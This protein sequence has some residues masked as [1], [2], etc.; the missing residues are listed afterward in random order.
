MDN[1]LLGFPRS[2]SGSGS[3]LLLSCLLLVFS[4]LYSVVHKQLIG[5]L[6]RVLL[7]L[8][9]L[10]QPALRCVLR[11][12]LPFNGVSVSVTRTAEAA[13]LFRNAATA[14]RILSKQ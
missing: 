8:L 2:G 1:G 3:D 4:P 14:P 9:L 11:S 10:R 7:L 12:S 6:S 5:A 13:L